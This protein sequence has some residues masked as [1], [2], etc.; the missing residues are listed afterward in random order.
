LTCCLRYSTEVLAIG[1][2]WVCACQLRYAIS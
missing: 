2:L 1:S